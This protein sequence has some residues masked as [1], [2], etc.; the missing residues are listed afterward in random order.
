MCTKKIYK[1]GKYVNKKN[2][3]CWKITAVKRF[4]TKTAALASFFQLND[5]P[6][7][8]PPKSPTIEE[9]RDSANKIKKNII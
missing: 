8:P 7:S 4:W 6:E 5:A 3:H 1:S 2:L 9:L